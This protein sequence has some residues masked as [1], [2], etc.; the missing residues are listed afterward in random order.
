MFVNTHALNWSNSYQVEFLSPFHYMTLS[1]KNWE[2]P[3]SRIWF[4]EMDIDCGLDFPSYLF[5]Q[6]PKSWSEKKSKE[7]EQTLEELNLARV[8]L[9]AVRKQNVS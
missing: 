6:V 1:H 8:R 2:L 5:L 9:N 4:A 3:K 7:D